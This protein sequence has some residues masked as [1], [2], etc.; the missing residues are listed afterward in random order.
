MRYAG[1]LWSQPDNEVRGNDN[2]QISRAR[3]LQGAICASADGDSIALVNPAA[4]NV[5]F[6]FIASLLTMLIRQPRW[7][8][9]TPARATATQWTTHDAGPRPDRLT[10]ASMIAYQD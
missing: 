7:W 10:A 6:I 4:S 9:A 3:W 2:V 1:R 5:V 8:R